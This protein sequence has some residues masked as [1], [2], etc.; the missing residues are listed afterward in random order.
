MFAAIPPILGLLA[1]YYVTTEAIKFA[2]GTSRQDW[3]KMSLDIS[4]QIGDIYE[5]RLREGK[6]FPIAG[7]PV[8]TFYGE[9][10]TLGAGALGAP[11]TAAEALGYTFPGAAA[12]QRQRL[13]AEVSGG[14]PF[15][16][17]RIKGAPTFAKRKLSTWNKEIKKAYKVA[18]VHKNQFG[19]R[20][21]IKVPKK[22]FPKI[23]KIVAALRKGKKQKSTAGKQIAKALKIKVSK[24][25]SKIKKTQKRRYG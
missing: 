7:D 14:F 21:V 4:E 25:V 1:R 16:R 13:E 18:K 23:V 5:A 6:V 15:T 8:G 12:K 17:A 10:V 2:T 11:G 3:I 19:G 20:G 24:F 9:L 22:A